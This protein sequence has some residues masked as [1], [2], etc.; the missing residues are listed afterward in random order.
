MG[1]GITESQNSQLAGY[2]RPRDWWAYMRGDYGSAQLSAAFRL[3]PS[4][5]EM[6]NV[7]VSAVVRSGSTAQARPH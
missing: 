2:F 6:A 3:V 5:P 7:V 4:S 1:E